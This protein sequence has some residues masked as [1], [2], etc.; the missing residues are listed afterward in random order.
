M[1]NR[2]QKTPTTIIPASANEV[3]TPTMITSENVMDSPDGSQ[4]LTLERKENNGEVTY[5]LF[6]SLK[7]DPNKQ[8]IYKQQIDGYK[9]LEIPF[10]TWSPDNKYL[11]IK[12]KSPTIDNYYVFQ[13]NGSLFTNNQ[14][15]LSIQELFNKSI[16]NYNIEE[17]TGWAD[18]LL[19]IVNTKSTETNDKVSFWFDVTSQ[20]FIQLG[21]Y[22]K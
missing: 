21:T 2:S 13:S 1:V 14:S 9:N 8:L 10:N 19:L 16:Q 17:V 12:E 4:T 18:P 7:S 5:L 3:I 15:Y 20:S 22:F 11:F 6:T